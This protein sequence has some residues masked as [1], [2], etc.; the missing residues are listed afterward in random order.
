MS[1]LALSRSQKA[2]KKN[3][4]A[5]EIIEDLRYKG[6]KLDGSFFKILTMGWGTFGDRFQ[7]FLIFLYV[8]ENAPTTQYDIKHHFDLSQPAVSRLI[9]ALST[10]ST[11]TEL[12]SRTY[13]KKGGKGLLGVS[14]HPK[15]YNKGVLVYLTK[16]GENYYKKLLKASEL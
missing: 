4:E 2:D 14:P 9:K 12:A 8:A 16:K 3:S 5:N 15:T 11:V 7:Q 13:T 6:P 10:F 1:P